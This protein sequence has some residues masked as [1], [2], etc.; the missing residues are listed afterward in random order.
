LQQLPL[1]ALLPQ[2]L[3]V[4]RSTVDRQHLAMAPHPLGQVQAGETR[5]AADVEQSLARAEAGPIPAGQHFWAPDLVLALQSATLF[6]MAAQDVGGLV[7]ADAAHGGSSSP[8]N[9]SG[10]G[11]PCDWPVA[12][13][14]SCSKRSC[15]A[16]T[17]CGG[18]AFQCS[19]ST[20]RIS[21]VPSSVAGSQSS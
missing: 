15:T 1:P 8:S 5:A 3:E 19:R 10:K 13:W 17:A 12:A 6:G 14:A 11:L 21:R 18:I 16:C 2:V 20:Q 9:T 7:G 4:G